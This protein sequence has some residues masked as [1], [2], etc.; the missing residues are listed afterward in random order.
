MTRRDFTTWEVQA[1]YKVNTVLARALFRA[2]SWGEYDRFTA[3]I[4]ALRVINAAPQSSL[5]LAAALVNFDYMVDGAIAKYEGS[6]VYRK[7]VEAAFA[8]YL[9]EKQKEAA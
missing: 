6:K 9:K 4:W 1:S 5:E 2:L 3:H 8:A 7:Q